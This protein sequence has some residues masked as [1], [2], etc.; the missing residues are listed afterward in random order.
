MLLGDNN[1]IIDKFDVDSVGWKPNKN[2][3][4]VETAG[5]VPLEVKFKMFEKNGIL[6]KVHE[7]NSY[8]SEE[9]R[10]LYLDPNLSINQYDDIETIVEKQARFELLKQSLSENNTS[11]T[12]SEKSETTVA[13]DVEKPV[14]KA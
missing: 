7:E 14:E 3:L 2:P 10:Q 5:F 8:T 13:P 9:L 1:Y 12:K 4:I 11:E 6:R